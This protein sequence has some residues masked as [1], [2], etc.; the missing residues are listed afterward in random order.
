MV[1]TD[2]FWQKIAAAAAKHVLAGNFDG[3]LSPLLLTV[4]LLAAQYNITRNT[5]IADLLEATFTGYAAISPPTFLGV[6]QLPSGAWVVQTDALQFLQTGTGILNTVYGWSLE[7]SA[8]AGQLLL[9][10]MFPTPVQMNAANVAINLSIPI[11][12]GDP[13]TPL[14]TGELV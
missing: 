5:V 8:D 13:A 10:E 1:G 9:A 4:R 7:T 2:Y 6:Y 11:Q 14:G 3:P 12:F